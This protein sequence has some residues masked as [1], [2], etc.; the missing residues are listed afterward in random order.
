MGKKDLEI[1]ISP[2]EGPSKFN[3][4]HWS[5][6]F[7]KESIL[8]NWPIANESAKTTW[9][10][11]T[12]RVS[13]IGVLAGACTPGVYGIVHGIATKNSDEV[14]AGALFLGAVGT[15]VMSSA[16]ETMRTRKIMHRFIAN[17]FDF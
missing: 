2:G 4:F 10:D 3:P 8:K 9:N 13:V 14:L 7:P 17:Q 1:S 11:I 15:A 16:H 12:Y 6:Q 5:P